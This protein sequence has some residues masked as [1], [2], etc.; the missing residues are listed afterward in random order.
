MPPSPIIPREKLSA[1]ERWE[2]RSFDAVREAP[3]ASAAKAKQAEARNRAEGY[4]AGRRE[5]IEAGR[6]EARNESAARIAQLDELLSALAGD[7]ARLDA[8]LA[9][10]VVELGLAVAR[11]IIGEAIRV[12][13]DVVLQAVQDALRHVARIRG[14]VQL[15]VHPDDAA[16][17]RE[18][19]QESASTRAWTLKENA[20]LA[21]GGCR[22]EAAG[23]EIDA[24]IAQRWQRIASALGTT[25]DWVE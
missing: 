24:S 9:Q 5:G 10:D 23:S 12:R 25:R 3:G 14:E 13:S 6:R 18:H 21:R 2:L 19:L 15:V 7:L 22:I 11:R 1:C 17:V 8:E 16:R 4:E 20:A